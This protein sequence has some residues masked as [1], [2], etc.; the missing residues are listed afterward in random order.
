M[1]LH[2]AL[3]IDGADDIDVVQDKRVRT[4]TKKPGRPFQAASGIE[5]DF[6]TRNLDPHAEVILR[7]QVVE[8][9]IGKVMHVD[10]HLVNPEG[11]QAF[12][13]DLQ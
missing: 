9:H 2:H 8:N 10:D 11:A 3:K 5:Q 6:L 12:E 4:F 13:C 7:F 1:K